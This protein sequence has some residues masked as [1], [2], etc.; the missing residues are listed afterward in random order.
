MRLLL[1]MTALALGAAPLYAT[2]HRTEE[3]MVGSGIICDTQEQALRIVALR[4]GGSQLPHAVLVVNEEA[5]NPHACGPALVAVSVAEQVQTERM[6][7]KRVTVTKMIVRAI[8][9]GMNWVQVPDTVQY[10]IV[11]PEGEEV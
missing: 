2:E 8:S 1:A 4:N 5:A 11:V 10:A 7:G 9:D 3:L 6:D